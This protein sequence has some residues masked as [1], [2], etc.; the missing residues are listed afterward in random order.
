MMMTP[1][2]TGPHLKLST[3]MKI[4]CS[5]K[6]GGCAVFPINTVMLRTFSCFLFGPLVLASR[7]FFFDRQQAALEH[8]ES[9]MSDPHKLLPED[10]DEKEA[11]EDAEG[12]NKISAPTRD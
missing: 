11:F 4:K 9:I 3:V 1:L 8:M 7:S 10:D 5:V 12:T 2:W 6:S